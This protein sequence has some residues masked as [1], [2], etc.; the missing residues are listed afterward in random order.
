MRVDTVI[1]PKGEGGSDWEQDISRAVAD[2][3]TDDLE[4][5]LDQQTE[6]LHKL[7]FASAAMVVLGGVLLVY[8]SGL[9]TVGLGLI[10]GGFLIGGGGV[11]Y[12]KSQ[13]PPVT[14]KNVECRLWTAHILPDEDGS[15]VYDATDTANHSELTL[16][17]LDNPEKLSLAQEFL[18][19]LDE[20]PVVMDREESVET[21]LHSTFD[22]VGN[23]LEQATEKTVSAP[24]IDDH[25]PVV[26]SLQQLAES[27]TDGDVDHDALAV[28]LE[29]AESD[30]QSIEELETLAFETDAEEEL[31]TIKSEAEKTVAEVSDTQ[32]TAID[33]LGDHISTVGNI[34][35]MGSYNFYCPSCAEDDVDSSLEVKKS[36]NTFSWHCDTCQSR[37]HNE[38]VI[39]KH[40]MKDGIVEP[41]WDQLWIEKDDE[42]RA[43]YENIEDQQSELKEREFEQRQEEIRRAWDQIKDLRSKIRD[44]RTD[45]RAAQG[46]VEQIGQ[47]MVKYERLNEER[48]QKFHQDVAEAKQEIDEMTEEIVEETRQLEQ[49][50][51]EEAQKEAE[52][53]AQLIREEE[54]QREREKF[55]AQQELADQ[56]KAAE[57][58]QRSEQ[59]T[60]EKLLETQGEISPLSTVNWYRL[61]KG[62]YFGHS[63]AGRN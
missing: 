35:T 31:Q 4:S 17:Q 55:I 27:A 63:K 13:S 60:E 12:I 54:R 28:D 22:S 53:K 62:E 40:E 16:K 61:K 7:I 20:L 46:T 19:E 34:L 58:E 47:M 52:E 45:A 56:R 32:E 11:A 21:D 37:F 10:A 39:P 26:E 23:E 9:V 30:V 41:V 2:V 25:H 42:R 43:I 29:K 18:E 51:I 49:Q 1:Q 50:K 24:I 38:L 59:H 57:L 5:F 6:R 36:G 15:I 33:I 8:G 14:V 44:L 3:V 48:K